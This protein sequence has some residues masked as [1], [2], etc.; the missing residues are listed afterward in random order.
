MRFLDAFR[1]EMSDIRRLLAGN[2]IELINE[3]ILNPVRVDLRSDTG[4]L[5]NKHYGLSYQ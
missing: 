2:N 3:K 4:K 5:I 1:N